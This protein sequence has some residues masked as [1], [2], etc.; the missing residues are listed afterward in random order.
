MRTDLIG[1]DDL[2]L[3]RWDVRETSLPT[4]ANKRFVSLLMLKDAVVDTS[5]DAGV[6]T[7]TCSPH[8]EH[9]IAVGR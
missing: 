8:T 6:T 4:L 1:G 9:L 2:K 5:F 3:K 7:I